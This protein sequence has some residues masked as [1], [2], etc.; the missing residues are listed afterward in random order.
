MA[1]NRDI[2][3]AYAA[4]RTGDGALTVVVIN[5]SMAVQPIQLTVAN[6]GQNNAVQLFQLSSVA[7]SVRRIG[8]SAMSGATF[9]FQSPAQSVTLAVI[10]SGP[11]GPPD[12][13][14]PTAV[15][16]AGATGGRRPVTLNWNANTET[17]L[18]GYFMQ[19]N[20]TRC[21]HPPNS[22]GDLRENISG[23][24]TATKCQRCYQISA[25]DLVE[26][27][28]LEVAS[29][30]QPQRTRHHFH[31]TMMRYE[32]VSETRITPGPMILTRQWLILALKGSRQLLVPGVA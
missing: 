28:D 3:S 7:N 26:M 10:S 22:G 8:N 23:S 18:L 15:A 27:L 29:F 20:P 2:V 16:G 19:S 6:P 31:F 13:T 5:K 11:A 25:V 24:W 9:S 21:P 30:A 1:N 17:D 14:A 12:T 4:E 32:M